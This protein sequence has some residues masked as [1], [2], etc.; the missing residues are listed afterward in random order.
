MLLFHGT[1]RMSLDSTGRLD[2]P[3][4]DSWHR[5]EIF[6][7]SKMFTP[8]LGPTQP[9]IR[10]AS[11]AFSPQG[12]WQGHDV[13]H[14]CPCSAKVK[15]EWSYTSTLPICLH[16]KDWDNLTFIF[17]S[18]CTTCHLSTHCLTQLQHSA[19]IWHCDASLGAASIMFSLFTW[20]DHVSSQHTEQTTLCQQRLLMKMYLSYVKHTVNSLQTDS[21][22]KQ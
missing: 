19:N 12:K 2:D 7:I 17:Y 4:F 8:A 21:T 6:M 14:L 1:W 15:I 20:N 10:L 16:G 9:P 13:D 22:N 18:T 11:E 5:Q 3:Q